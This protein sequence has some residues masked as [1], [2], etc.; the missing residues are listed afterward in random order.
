M[1]DGQIMEEA[2]KIILSVIGA[3]GGTGAIIWIILTFSINKIADRLEAK[4]QHKLDKELEKYKGEL[5]KEIDKLNH[6]LQNKNHISKV[7]FD[8]KIEAYKKLSEAF[9]DV[10]LCANTLIP[11]GLYKPLA[12]QEKQA[13]R[14]KEDFVN[15]NKATLEAQNILNSNIPFITEEQYNGY[16]D[17]L[18]M[19]RL[20][21]DDFERRWC[22]TNIFENKNHLPDE[23]YLRSDRM[24]TKYKELSKELN[25]YLSSL[26]IIE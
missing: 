21:I 22:V 14:E 26:E 16:N 4:Y 8:I 19:A 24:A 18:K 9:F 5:Q 6:K 7:L 17:I 1:E 10:V 2:L 23:A 3:A 13:E 12:D 25:R 20:H 11:P 15:L